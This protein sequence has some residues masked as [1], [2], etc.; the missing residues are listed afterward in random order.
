MKKK[1]KDWNYVHKLLKIKYEDIDAIDNLC[2]IPKY[3]R[4]NLKHIFKKLDIN[5][6]EELYY[7]VV[8]MLIDIYYYSDIKRR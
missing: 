3:T 8:A 7:T 5:T 2:A 6:Q 4:E 1:F